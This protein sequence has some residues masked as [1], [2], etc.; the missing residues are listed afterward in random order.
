M[1]QTLGDDYQ[2]SSF[3]KIITLLFSHISAN[4]H[5]HWRRTLENVLTDM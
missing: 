3:I 1:D 2:V 4:F 5:P